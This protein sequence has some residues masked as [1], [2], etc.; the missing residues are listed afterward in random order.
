MVSTADMI[1]SAGPWRLLALLLLALV[2]LALR[3][4]A[5]PLA[6]VALALDRAAV[7]TGALAPLPAPTD[8]RGDTR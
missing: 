6:G 8:A 1:T 2:V 5:W 4:A 7:L 3:L